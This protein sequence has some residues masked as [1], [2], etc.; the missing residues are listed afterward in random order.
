MN[1]SHW[2]QEVSQCRESEIFNLL[3]LDYYYNHCCR[4]NS[5]SRC[6]SVVFSRTGTLRSKQ[7]EW[8]L[9]L[10]RRSICPLASMHLKM[11]KSWLINLQHLPILKS[12][13]SLSRYHLSSYRDKL[14]LD[15]LI[16]WQKCCYLKAN[17]ESLKYLWC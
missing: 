3:D 14:H 11:K 8:Q 4:S 2:N 12:Y 1:C 15:Q 13:Q 17:A 7:V 16:I 5:S 10:R 9:N 6:M